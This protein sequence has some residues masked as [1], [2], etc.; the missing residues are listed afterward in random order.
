MLALFSLHP[1][2][3]SHVHLSR[4]SYSFF[5]SSNQEIYSM[6]ITYVQC[7][8]KNRNSAYT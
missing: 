2:S 1:A 8:N 5:P 6:K 3:E 4:N 7:K